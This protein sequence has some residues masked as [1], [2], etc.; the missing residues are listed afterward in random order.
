MLTP[1]PNR[2]T[3]NSEDEVEDEDVV[4]EI[5]EKSLAIETLV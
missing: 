2:I 1:V 5:G 3:I 4:E